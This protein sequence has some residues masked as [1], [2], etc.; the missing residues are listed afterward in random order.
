MGNGYYSSSKGQGWFWY[1]TPPKKSKKKIKKQL[2]LPSKKTLMTMP[3]LQF[4]KVLKQFKLKAISEPTEQNVYNY[5]K[6]QAVA[7]D[8]ARQF[9]YMWRYVMTEH[10]S[11]N[12]MNTHVGGSSQ[13]RN[14]ISL[15]IN[16]NKRVAIYKKLRK[17]MGLVL[18][19]SPSNPYSLQELLQ[20]KIVANEDGF[21]YA[22]INANN[23]PNEVKKMGIIK[24]PEIIMIYKHK[25]GKLSHY[26]V[27]IG[28]R[29][30]VKIKHNI[31]YDYEAFIK[32]KLNYGSKY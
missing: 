28:L 13:Y 1:Q 27:A 31:L 3:A 30:Q 15:Q 29:T 19:Y 18:F 6:V 9:A 14:I 11:L 4:K 8:R 10:P 22:K 17:Q 5:I 20:L 21:Y 24:L 23:H 7:G 25:N 16:H 32:H 26:P 2:K 12:Y